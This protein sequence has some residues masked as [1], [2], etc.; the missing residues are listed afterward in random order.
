MLQKS[1]RPCR[2][3][4]LDYFL[5]ASLCSSPYSGF[6][7]IP[8]YLLCQP[9]LAACKVDLAETDPSRRQVSAE[10]GFTKAREIGAIRFL[11][12]SSQSGHNIETIFNW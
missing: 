5:L 12:T 6:L 1:V 3:S 11:E 10:E 7:I 2:F 4:C 8:F 9:A